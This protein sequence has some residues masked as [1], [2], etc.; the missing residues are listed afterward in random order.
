MDGIIIFLMIVQ[1]IATAIGAFFLAK[2][3]RSLRLAITQAAAIG[4]F[5]PILIYI[6]PYSINPTLEKLTFFIEWVLYS[7]IANEVAG[8]PAAIIGKMIGE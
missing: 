4:F 6:I 8:I 2:Q 5:L 3:A 7:M 1:F